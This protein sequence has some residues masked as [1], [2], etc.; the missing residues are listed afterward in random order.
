MNDCAIVIMSG[1]RGERFW[2]KSR[3]NKPKQTLSIGT[4]KPM[5]VEAVERAVGLV[6]FS[7]IFI[8]T[9]T[10]LDEPFR[11]LLHD[12]NVQF[13]IEPVARDTAAAIGY[14]SMYLSQKYGK[15]LLVAF[16]GSD[17]LIPEKKLF[18]EH[19]K[20]AFELARTQNLIVTIGIVPTRPATG[21]GYIQMGEHLQ[22]PIDGFEAYKVKAFREK[23]NEEAAE[24]Y[25]DT[26]MYLWNSGM[27]VTKVGVM[28]EEIQANI[29]DLYASLSRM[30]ESKF[31]KDIIQQEFQ[32]LQ[33][34]SI[35]FAVMEKT[36]RIAV[37]RGKFRWDDMGDWQAFARTSDKDALGNIVNGKW[38]GIKTKNCVILSQNKLIGTIGLNDLIIVETN[39]AILICPKEEAQNV[40]KLV[41][42]IG[43]KEDYRE[44]I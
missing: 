27:F 38:V 18:Q 40:K 20:A 3:I 24:E 26:G 5:L 44:Y 9:G 14:S 34:I 11:Q 30:A 32:D 1:G 17:Y 4:E 33:K 35:D 39:D 43:N 12:Y 37:L 15:N 6:D 25:L 23:P 19:I 8:S 41:Q 36:K 21:Y 22:D 7:K 29:P 16:V 13:L 2:P 31:A 10:L 42:K 28:L